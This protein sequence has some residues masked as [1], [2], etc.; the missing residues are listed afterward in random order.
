[1]LIYDGEEMKGITPVIS[2]VL[3]VLIAVTIVGF[4]F[5]FLSRAVST[6]TNAT[7]T[8]LQAQQQIMQKTVAVVNIN[9]DQISVTNTGSETV[10]PSSEVTFYVDGVMRSCESW[11]SGSIAPR[12]TA[13]CDLNVTCSS[14]SVLKV[15]SP[16]WSEEHTC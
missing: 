5:L 10:Y 1:M 9:G 12:E 16:G 15:V 14:G 3:L 6:G 4:V 8:Q 11:T 2:I 13:T 7:G